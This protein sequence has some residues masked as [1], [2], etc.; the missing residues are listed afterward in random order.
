MERPLA[1][2]SF[3]PERES[4]NLNW[5]FKCR[6]VD[7]RLRIFSCSGFQRG[8]E[9]RENPILR[10]ASRFYSSVLSIIQCSSH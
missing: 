7:R 1:I 5:R 9:I 3:P 10:E 8:L 2:L 4:L 6:N